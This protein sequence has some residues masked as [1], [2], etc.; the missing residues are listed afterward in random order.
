MIS[1]IFVGMEDHLFFRPLKP[2]F[3]SSL[4]ASL[5]SSPSLL[6]SPSAVVVFVGMLGVRGSSYN[7]FG[8]PR[9]IFLSF[10]AFGL[11]SDLLANGGRLFTSQAVSFCHVALMLSKAQSLKVIN[12]L[13]KAGYITK[14]KEGRCQYYEFT[15]RAKE[16]YQALKA[17]CQQVESR[18]AA[19]IREALEILDKK[20][21]GI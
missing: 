5:L 20:K 1:C 6:L 13:L 12:Q 19:Y 10:V 8:L 17:H 16:K 21:S 9:A 11:A 4:R 3:V 18:R 14:T 15:P 2:L 7:R